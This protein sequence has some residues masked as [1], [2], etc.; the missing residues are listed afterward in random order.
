MIILKA[1]IIYSTT[2]QRKLRF[3]SF[4]GKNQ[5]NAAAVSYNMEIKL[6]NYT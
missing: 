3:E 5:M 1:G 6:K 2:K 4:V